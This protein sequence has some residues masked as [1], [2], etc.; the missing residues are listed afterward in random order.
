MGQSTDR[1]Y[2]YCEK[3]LIDYEYSLSSK[4]WEKKERERGE[5]EREELSCIECLLSQRLSDFFTCGGSLNLLSSSWYYHFILKR[6]LKF[7]NVKICT[8]ILHILHTK[9]VPLLCLSLR[10]K[11]ENYQMWFV[12]SRK[13]LSNCMTTINKW[14]IQGYISRE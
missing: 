14:L 7:W 12:L 3:N 10:Y 5:Q 9:N 8:F 13:L 2:T 6:K 1:Y 4:I 11:D